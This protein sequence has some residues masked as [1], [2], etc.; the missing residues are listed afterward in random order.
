MIV[1]LVVFSFIA[2]ANF[3]IIVIAMNF[4][5]VSSTNCYCFIDLVAAAPVPLGSVTRHCKNLVFTILAVRLNCTRVFAAP[6]QLGSVTRH[7]KNLASTANY[8]DYYQMLKIIV[9]SNL[10]VRVLVMVHIVDLASAISTKVAI[11]GRHCC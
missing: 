5:I 1:E 6:A 11:S 2:L 4:T 10:Y 7:C 3:K 9:P 8:F